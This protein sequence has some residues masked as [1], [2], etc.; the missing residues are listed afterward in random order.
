MPQTDK[1]EVAFVFDT[2][3]IDSGWYGG[4]VAGSI[5]PL[6][7]RGLNCSLLVGDLLCDDQNLAFSLLQESLTLHKTCE[8]SHTSQLY[9]VYINNLS[10]ARFQSIHEALVAQ[11]EYIGYIQS[12]YSSG[13]KNL[14][15]LTLTPAYLKFKETFICSHED[16]VSNSENSNTPSWPL[17]QHRFKCVSVQ[18]MYFD[19]FLS[20]KIERPVY[21]RF[22]AD[23]DFA[24]A[25]ISGA[26]AS[27]D[28]LTV[29]IDKSKFEYLRSEKA[30]SLKRAGLANASLDELRA[31]I[32]AKMSQNYIYHLRYEH[33]ASLF[34]IILEL[35][36]PDTSSQV[37][38][39][40]AFEYKA[41]AEKLRLV[42]LY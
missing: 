25:A 42:T 13:L 22:S 15:S 30:G 10:S 18:S 4:V 21:P 41:Q 24:L 16:D 34:N 17:A 14:L 35:N 39:I 12:T 26:S 19:M 38:L 32:F 7:D 29:V 36:V 5:V 9:C 6:L 33:D 1:F 27:V 3:K 31:V 8:I 20:Y 11:P 37:R 23:T 2:H 40:A 28:E